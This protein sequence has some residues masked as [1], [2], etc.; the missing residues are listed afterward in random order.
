MRSRHSPIALLVLLVACR[1]AHAAPPRTLEECR[2]TAAREA[3]TEAGAKAMLWDCSKKFAIPEPA[4][5]VDER[6]CAALGKVFEPG[7]IVGPKCTFDPAERPCT[8]EDMAINAEAQVSKAVCD[9]RGDSWSAAQKL[10]FKRGRLAMTVVCAT[11]SAPSAAQ[12]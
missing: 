12:R 10:C 8:A 1:G 11:P 2:A 5:E 9:A 6:E 7:R 3:R 4:A